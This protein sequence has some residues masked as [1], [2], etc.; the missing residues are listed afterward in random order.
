MKT[1]YHTVGCLK[2]LLVD[3]KKYL[4]TTPTNLL[5]RRCR[6]VV[7][8]LRWRQMTR[9]ECKKLMAQQLTATSSRF[10]NVEEDILLGVNVWRVRVF[11]VVKLLGKQ[12]LIITNSGCAIKNT[13]WSILIGNSGSV[14][15]I[16]ATRQS[17]RPNWPPLTVGA[18][19]AIV[20]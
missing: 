17:S 19:V 11:N 2:D 18:D 9:R 4:L 6:W 16:C 12:P 8:A 20:C 14:K 13:M 10:F 1:G 15:F 5:V 7:S 3:L